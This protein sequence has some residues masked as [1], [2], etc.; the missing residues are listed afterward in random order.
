MN[1]YRANRL[2][3]MINKKVKLE[4]K[5]FVE[6]QMDFY[7]TPAKLFT[8]HFQNIKMDNAELQNYVD[9]LLKWNGVLSP[10]IIEVRCI[11]SVKKMIVKDCLKLVLMTNN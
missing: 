4:P 2:D 3:E 11:K 5:D 9:L 6:M 8:S 10:D 1:G 7:C